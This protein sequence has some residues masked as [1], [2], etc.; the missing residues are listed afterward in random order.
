M[1]AENSKAIVQF[2]AWAENNLVIVS[3]RRIFAAFCVPSKGSKPQSTWPFHSEFEFKVDR[4]GVKERKGG[5]K[6]D[7]RQQ[8]KTDFECYSSEKYTCMQL[9]VVS[10]KSQSHRV[11]SVGTEYGNVE[12]FKVESF[13]NNQLVDRKRTSYQ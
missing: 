11:M 13:Q 4:I 9:G 7:G 12:L 10:V 3:E 6:G 5:Q 2:I 1:F 8:D